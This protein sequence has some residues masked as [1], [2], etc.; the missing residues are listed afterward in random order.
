MVKLL[1][2]WDELGIPHEECKQIYGPILPIIGFE[3]D[4]NL[5]QAQMSDKSCEHL[6]TFISEFAHQGTHHSLCD[7]QQLAGYLNWALSV[8]PLLCPGLSAIYAKTVGKVHQNALLWVN[9]DV[10]QELS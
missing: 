3:V 9:H 4:P 10:V 1:H 2:L 7:F 5:M 6:I 8:Y